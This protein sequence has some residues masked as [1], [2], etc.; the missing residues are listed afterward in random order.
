[1]QGDL[2]TLLITIILL[3]MPA[4][5]LN[6]AEWPLE[7]ETVVPVLIISVIFGFFLARSP[8]NEFFALIVSA[9]YGAIFVLGVAT[10]NE[11]GGLVEGLASVLE[12]T[13]SWTIDAFT[14]GIN[15]DSLVFTLLVAT[16]FW[17][18]G[19][20]AVWHIFRIDRVWR[21]ILPPG[22]ILIT[23]MMV[24]TGDANLDV[25]LA[26]FAFMSLLLIVRSNLDAREWDWYVSGIRVPKRMRNQFIRV[27]AVLSLVAL[28]FAWAI[29]TADIE[30]RLA[31]FQEFLQSD[32]VQ[33][34]AEMWNRLFEPVESD[35][36]ATSDYYGG[37][38]LRLGGAISLGDQV[39]FRVEVPDDRRYYWRSRV[40]ERYDNGRWESAALRRVTDPTAPLDLILNDELIGTSRIDVTQTYTMAH[41]SRLIYA[42]P[43]PVTVNLSGRYDVFRITG[44]QE[45]T[46]SPVN[47]SVMRPLRVFNEGDEYRVTSSMSVATAYELREAGTNYPEW[48][49]NPN[50][51]IGLSVSEEVKQLARQ[52]ISDA[53]ANNPYDQAKAI[54]TWL[55]NNITYNERI[56]APPAGVD[57]VWWFLNTQREGYCTYYA[58][59]MVTM[60]RSLGIPARMAAGFAEGDY[61]AASGEFIVRERDA[62][63]WVEAYFPG[64]GWVEFEPTSAQEPLNREGDL[65]Q[66]KSPV[67][68]PEQPVSQPTSTPTQIPSPTPQATQPS[69]ELNQQQPPTLTPTPSP[70]PTATPVIVPTVEPPIQPPPSD[71]FLS[72]LLPAIG[73]A[74]L[75]FFGVVALVLFGV[76][77][78]WWWEWRGMGGLSPVSRAYARLERYL[79]LIGIRSADTETPEERREVVV[80]RLPVAERPVST[81][82][83]SYIVERYAEPGKTTD[84]RQYGEQVADEA[85]HDT[86]SSILKRWLRR[87][88]PWL[89]D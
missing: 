25:P 78:Y 80:K 60:L 69:N 64:Y 13:V 16:L 44:N 48:V 66:Q 10:I 19:Y 9:V 33:E 53:G 47:V 6:A 50:A 20:N 23:N 67:A 68:P 63:T 22:L 58:T 87:F 72:F 37:D 4:F 55:R 15:Q 36:P 41:R 1:M 38:S 86:R 83:R 28:L 77:L 74:V 84:E 5:A 17:Y 34:F 79:P 27:G 51:L 8:Y 29:P 14:G 18:L 7:M 3:L 75:L 39:V 2:T 30:A 24:Y 81:I 11:P 71:D 31:E 59:A 49:I 57:P 12:R 85:W 42:A 45:D 43:Q 32:P 40:L 52:I 62:H 89:R 21:V 61:D 65:P 73:A 35:G 70:T 82:T 56:P 26:V 46:S 54:E 88:V 76:F